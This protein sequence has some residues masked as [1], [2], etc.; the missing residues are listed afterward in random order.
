MTVDPTVFWM[1]VIIAMGGAYGWLLRT[2]LKGKDDQ[3][4]AL[5]AQNDFLLKLTLKSTAV[6]EKAVDQKVS[7]GST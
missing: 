3:I 4:A 1:T 7:N 6:T 2:M 5:T